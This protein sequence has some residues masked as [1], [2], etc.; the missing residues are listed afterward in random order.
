MKKIAF[1]LFAILFLN[2]CA[3]IINGQ[4]AVVKISA[5]KESKIVFLKDTI[6]I[7][8]QQIKIRPLRSKNP[9]KITVLKDN[10]KKDF[11]FNRKISGLFWLNIFNNY[12]AGMLVDL[13]NNKRFRYKHNLH[14]VTDT[15]SKKIVLSDKKVTVLPKN[16]FFLYT[17]PLQS[18]DF[19]SVPIT[20]LGA[21][22]FIKDNFSFS[23]EYGIKV[24]DTH[25]ERNTISY[26]KDK[27]STFRFETKL[28][29]NINATENVHLNE[30]LSL[31]FRK[32]KSQY[33]DNINYYDQNNNYIKDDFATQK[34]VTIVNLKYGFLVPLGKKFYFD[35]YS[36][37]GIRTKKFHHINL[38]YDKS[39]HQIENNDF[40]HFNFREFKN[41]T[42]KSLLNLSL[43]FKFG[44]K[45]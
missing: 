8:K 40:P 28:Y 26:L 34:N 10:L 14:F 3:S 37:L 39:I 11:S 24:V 2:S 22:Y 4:K 31:E 25:K 16:T 12:G 23:T 35:F 44:I 33:N 32:I 30:Y 43:G 13:T 17:S 19:F 18:F 27:A 42:K 6:S 29:N 7:N 15:I 1:F 5:D 21:E 36:G 20:T 38:E 41:Y 9:L 45:L